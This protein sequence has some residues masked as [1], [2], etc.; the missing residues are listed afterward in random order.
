MNFRF[1]FFFVVIFKVY[2]SSG[3]GKVTFSDMLNVLRDLTGQF[4]SEQQS[5]VGSNQLSFSFSFPYHLSG[6]Q[7]N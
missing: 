3:N 2:D 4:I 5:E 7:D 6:C 1:C